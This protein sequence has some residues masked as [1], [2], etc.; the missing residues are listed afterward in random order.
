MMY[1]LAHA[2]Y[3]ICYMHL[4][5][6]SSHFADHDINVC[7]KVYQDHTC[8]HFD[9]SSHVQL[10]SLPLGIPDNFFL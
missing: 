10:R 2:K 4:M 8:I 5:T 1:P 6:K 7:R 9:L 3:A